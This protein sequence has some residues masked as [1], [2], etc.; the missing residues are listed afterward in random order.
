[1]V[2]ELLVCEI[3]FSFFKVRL[4]QHHL[5]PDDLEEL[6][7]QQP[8]PPSPKA[9]KARLWKVFYLPPFFDFKQL[10]RL[11]NAAAEKA[12]REINQEGNMLK[13]MI[14]RFSHFL[15]H[16]HAWNR[17]VW[18]DEVCFSLFFNDSTDVIVLFWSEGT[19]ENFKC[20]LFCSKNE[21]DGS[22]NHVSAK[23]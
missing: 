3:C 14:Q 7:R 20:Q 2:A 22:L 19:Q 18:A 11:H 12:R 5:G 9:A 6:F 8:P 23:D 10:L 13:K 21:E 16:S 4:K 15:D 17:K 1:M